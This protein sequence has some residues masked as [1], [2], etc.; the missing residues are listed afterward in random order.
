MT[1]APIT[2][3]RL[4][5]DE[6]GFSHK[7]RSFAL[8]DREKAQASRLDLSRVHSPYDLWNSKLPRDA[9]VVYSAESDEQLRNLKDRALEDPQYEGLELFCN[10]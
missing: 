1:L 10:N 4:H 9:Y 6:S 2:R 3:V 8:V 7:H 5:V